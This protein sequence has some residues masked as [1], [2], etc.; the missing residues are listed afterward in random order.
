MRP[1]I[2]PPSPDASRSDSRSW[3]QVLPH[4]KEQWEHHKERWPQEQRPP[5]DRSTDEPGSWRGDNDQYLNAEENIV[6]GHA[7]ERI[8]QVENKVTASLQEIKA[9]PRTATLRG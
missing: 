1:S 6:A 9:S 4:L 5:V 3:W 8:R 2:E 7:M